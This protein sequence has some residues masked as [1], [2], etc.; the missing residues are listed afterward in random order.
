MDRIGAALLLEFR[1]VDAEHSDFGHAIE[2][3]SVAVMN[4]CHS[5]G[6]GA[7][8]GG[9]QEKGDCATGYSA[10]HSASDPDEVLLR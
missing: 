6:K 9:Q 1:R 8:R 2:G 7:A 5:A 3:K 10:K 4:G